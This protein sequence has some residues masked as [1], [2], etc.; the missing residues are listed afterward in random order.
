MARASLQYLRKHPEILWLAAI[1]AF[2]TFL[3]LAFLHEPFDRDEGQYATIAQTILRGGLPYRD[4]VEI[5]PPGVFYLYA[6]AI[7]VLG[8]SPEAIRLFTA[9]YATL[10]VLAVYAVA[11]ELSGKR[12]GLYAALVYGICSTLPLL[13][14]SSSN[15]EVFLVLPLTVGLWS[16]LRAM[17]TKQRRYLFWCGLSGAMAMLIKP[18]ALPMVG[19]EF[20]LILFL[21][22]GEGQLKVRARDLGAF[23]L[24][25]ALCALAVL[26][27]F[28]LRGGLGDF[29]YWTVKYPQKYRESAAGGPLFARSFSLLWLSLLLPVLLGVPSAIWLATKKR[30]LAGV[31]PLLM[32]V[33]ACLAVALPGKYFP[34]YFITL[35]PFLA[36]PAGIGLSC[37]ARLPIIAACFFWLMVASAATLSILENFQFYTTDSPEAVSTLKFGSSHFVDSVKVAKYLKEHTAPGDYI[38]QWGLEPELYFLSDRR[39]PNPFLV[40]LVPG[41]S[42]DPR[43]AVERL[44]QSLIDSKPAY[45]VFQPEWSVFVGV[46]EVSRY[47]HANC[48]GEGN[49]AYAI[50]YRCTS[51]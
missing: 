6:L 24:P 18:V 39:C 48:V 38:F 28:Y 40:S 2:S 44:K 51:P 11:R 25:M 26:A 49:I 47:I 4:A 20:L 3:R 13:Q 19:V 16:L 41:W 10:T 45:I 37:A 32:L 30:D 23:L 27:Y 35:V 7:R 42:E 5:K 17:E 21:R 31:L 33:A 43:Q 22:S 14:A 15:T 34:H 36:I 50:M 12:A 29:L 9:G 46:D 1:L 8:A